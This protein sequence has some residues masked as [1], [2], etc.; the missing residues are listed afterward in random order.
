MN[1]RNGKIARLPRVRLSLSGARRGAAVPAA[2][3]PGVPPG[4][5][6]GGE[7]P[8]KPA[9][10]T[11]APHCLPDTFNHT[12]LVEKAMDADNREASNPTPSQSVAVSRS[13]KKSVHHDLYKFRFLCHNAEAKAEL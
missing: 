5:R 13:D 2:G 4:D 9:A 12:P 1:A 6:P 3:S 8:P 11:A 7:T 10:G